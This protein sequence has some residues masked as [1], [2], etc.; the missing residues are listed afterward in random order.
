MSSRK[1]GISSKSPISSTTNRIADVTDDPRIQSS[2]VAI[3]TNSSDVNISNNP[4][5]PQ[6]SD[7]G[8]VWNPSYMQPYPWDMPGYPWSFSRQS[9]PPPFTYSS[10]N[11]MPQF[12]AAS[13]PSQS[14]VYSSSVPAPQ[15]FAMA[16]LSVLALDRPFVVKIFNKKN[17]EMHRMWI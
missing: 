11:P 16:P 5:I 4:I 12:S 15:F 13:I 6:S 7:S 9:Y 14:N 1:K 3:T 10:M 2:V 8:Q 17:K